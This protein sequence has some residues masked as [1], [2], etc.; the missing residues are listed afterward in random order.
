MRAGLGLAGVAGASF[1]EVKNQRPEGKRSAKN[2][3]R[4]SGR[5][6]EAGGEL[7]RRGWGHAG[8]ACRRDA[9]RAPGGG[10]FIDTA[11]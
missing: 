9:R 10:L 1:D 5:G 8:G 6:G 3:G 7:G 2:E 4:V 11:T